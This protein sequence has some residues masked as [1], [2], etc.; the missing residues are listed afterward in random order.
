MNQF[1]AE[2]EVK[3][4]LLRRGLTHDRTTLIEPVCS[5]A[6]GFARILPIAAINGPCR[7]VPAAASGGCRASGRLYA[8]RA[9]LRSVSAPPASRISRSAAAR[10]QS[11]LFSLDRA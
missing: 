3:E 7:A 10:S 6:A 5:G 1:P 2:D 9:P 4:L 8:I 11:R